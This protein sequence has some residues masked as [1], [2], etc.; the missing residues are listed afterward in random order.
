MFFEG[1]VNSEMRLLLCHLLEL[2]LIKLQEVNAKIASFKGQREYTVPPPLR[3][4]KIIAKTKLSYSSAEMLSL[5]LILPLILSH[6]VTC[7]TSPHYSNFILLMEILACSQ[8]Y[9]FL[10]DCLIQLASNIKVHNVAFLLLYKKKEGNAITSNW[11]WLEWLRI[12]RT[13]QC[14]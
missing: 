3:R 12:F 7:E 5:A 14:T 9:S 1:I 10:E 8:G 4:D 11:E 13:T 2:K 6:Y